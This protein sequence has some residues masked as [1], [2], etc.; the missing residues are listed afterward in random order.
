[1][2]AHPILG[3]TDY[4]DY[5]NC[6]TGFTMVQDADKVIARTIKN[7]REFLIHDYLSSTK[8]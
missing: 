7:D 8:Q 6:C 2:T 3:P 1:M 4:Y 5:T